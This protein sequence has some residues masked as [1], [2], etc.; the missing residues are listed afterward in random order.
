MSKKKIRATVQQLDRLVAKVA[1]IDAS[2]AVEFDSL[3]T[4]IVNINSNADW[5][6]H[7]NLCA[8]IARDY[9]DLSSM[10]GVSEKSVRNELR[11]RGVPPMKSGPKAAA[12]KYPFRKYLPESKPRQS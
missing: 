10:L 11:K 7:F 12:E 4:Q 6:D 5:R 3:R 8:D 9:A 1:K 2:L